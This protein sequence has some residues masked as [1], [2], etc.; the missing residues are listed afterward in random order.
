MP[1]GVN[2]YDEGRIQ[3]RNFGLADGTQIVSPGFITD[4]LVYLMDVGNAACYPTSG[5]KVYDISGYNI[6]EGSFN[7]SPTFSLSGGGS[8]IF[9]GSGTTDYVSVPGSQWRAT[10]ATF[11][12]WLY[13]NGAQLGTAGLI[14]YSSSLAGLNFFGTTNN[15]AYHW[16]A[17]S[18]TFNYNSGL[19]PPSLAW[20]MAALS[21]YSDRAVF[22]LCQGSGTTTATNTTT[23]SPV[24]LNGFRIGHTIGTANRYFKGNIAIAAIYDRALS[25][26]EITQNFTATRARFGI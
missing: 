22:T 4:N 14:F 6:N 11:L 7:D 5:T 24:L 9:D 2:M 23:H 16:N 21:V 17:A 3:E 1:R 10:E 15:L 19:Q 13:R 25:P 26:E 20:S 8:L 12:I 18:A